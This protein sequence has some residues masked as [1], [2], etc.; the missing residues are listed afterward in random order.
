MALDNEPVLSAGMRV[1]QTIR[2]AQGLQTTLNLGSSMQKAAQH[3][4]REA[5]K[6]YVLKVKVLMVHIEDK[7]KVKFPADHPRFFFFC[8]RNCCLC[9]MHQ[10]VKE[11]RH[12]KKQR[13]TRNKPNN[14][15]QESKHTNQTD[16]KH[17][18]QTRTPQPRQIPLYQVTHVRRVRRSPHRTGETR[19]SLRP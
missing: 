4:L 3:L 14:R 16:T 1:A 13:E 18:N 12:A 7:M 6:R 9:A 10:S 5:S 17:K 2:A 8:S 11:L 15:K 19:G